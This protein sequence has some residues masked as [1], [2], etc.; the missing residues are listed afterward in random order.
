MSSRFAVSAGLLA[1]GAGVATKR[2]P[3]RRQ[4]LGT[5]AEFEAWREVF[6]S[7][8]DMF[9]DLEPYGV[10]DPTSRIVPRDQLPA[11]R[12]AFHEAAREAWGRLGARFLAETED[13]SAWALERFG[14]P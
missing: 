14:R 2:T 4:R 1:V 11:A 6:A 10:L 9:G 13:T 5:A 8:F 12:D 3:I 7:G